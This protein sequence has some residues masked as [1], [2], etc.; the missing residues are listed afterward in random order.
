MDRLQHRLRPP[1]C[2]YVRIFH[3]ER[4]GPSRNSEEQMEQRK[5]RLVPKGEKGHL[6]FP[7]LIVIAD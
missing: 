2:L 6:P 1:L 7:S 3:P 5:H 4:A